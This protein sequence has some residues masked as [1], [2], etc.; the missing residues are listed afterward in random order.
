MKVVGQQ[1]VKKNN[2]DY[3]KKGLEGFT[4]R[5]G[6]IQTIPQLGRILKQ[7]LK[8]VKNS[9]EACKIDVRAKSIYEIIS[10]GEKARAE[11]KENKDG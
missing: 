8:D 6:Y 11:K 5:E 9:A 7:E 10:A 3:E 1:K 2:M 4:R